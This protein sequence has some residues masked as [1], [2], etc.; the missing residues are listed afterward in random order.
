MASQTVVL[1]YDGGNTT[2]SS[3]STM[4]FYMSW[5][6][7]VRLDIMIAD[8]LTDNFLNFIRLV[9]FEDFRFRTIDYFEENF[10]GQLFGRGWLRHILCNLPRHQINCNLLPSVI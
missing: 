8:S 10:F 6:E 9:L 5:K 4:I 2:S 7:I 3:K 1:G